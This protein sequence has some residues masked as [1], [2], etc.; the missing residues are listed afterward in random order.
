SISAETMDGYSFTPRWGTDPDVATYWY[1]AE[2]NGRN[3]HL[4]VSAAIH[5]PVDRI[6]VERMYCDPQDFETDIDEWALTHGD[7]RVIVWPTFKATQ[8]YEELRRFET[9]LFEG[10]IR[11]DGCPV[12][13]QHMLNARKVPVRGAREKYILGKPN[14]TQKI[15]AA[16]TR[17]LAHTA[18]RDA[19]SDGW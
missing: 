1:P 6:D 9:D 5:A 15:D 12:A 13:T 8:M 10:R 19:I 4:E 17:I 3:T 18:A 16:M 11:H 7:E 14:D 2:H